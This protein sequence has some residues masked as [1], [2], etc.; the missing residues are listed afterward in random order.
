MRPSGP[1]SSLKSSLVH[2]LPITKKNK[3]TVVTEA[4]KE[5]TCAAYAL[6]KLLQKANSGSNWRNIISHTPKSQR[7]INNNE[8]KA[9]Y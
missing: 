8:Q 4:Q 1:N 2:T 5:C 7:D 9:A 3:Y 6:A